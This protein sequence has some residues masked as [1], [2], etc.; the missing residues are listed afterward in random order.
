MENPGPQLM[1]WFRSSRCGVTW[2]ALFALACQ[3]V[4][5]F[6]HVHPG[7]TGGYPGAWAVNGDHS[8]SLT[9]P[10]HH[11]NPAGLADDF[12]AICASINLASTLVMPE[13]P[14]VAPSHPLARYLDWSP[15]AVEAASLDHLL[16]NARAPP[17]A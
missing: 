10:S 2:L 6:G 3:L 5:A 13:S 12:C 8:A 11:E 7:K 4:F 9:A 17:L 15:V 16:F 1:S 14:A